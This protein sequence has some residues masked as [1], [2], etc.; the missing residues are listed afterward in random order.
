MESVTSAPT[1]SFD[2]TSEEFAWHA[3]ER[4]AE[5][6]ERSP[7]RRLLQPGGTEVRLVSRYEE[8]RVWPTA[9]GGS[10]ADPPAGS[11]EDLRFRLAGYQIRGLHTLPVR[12]HGR[13]WYE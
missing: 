13:G 1:V 12:P 3:Y 11:G 2:P 6:R 10:E 4:Y 8:A 9:V 7:A 5:L